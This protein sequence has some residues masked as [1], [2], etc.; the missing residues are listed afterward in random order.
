MLVGYDAVAQ[1]EH[2]P[3]NTIYDAKRFIGKTFTDK[4]IIQAQKQY[5]FKV[6]CLCIYIAKWWHI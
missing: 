1:E 6:S 3:E 2:N 4:E 5:P